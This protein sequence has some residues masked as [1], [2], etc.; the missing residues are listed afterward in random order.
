MAQ[1][2]NPF[3]EDGHEISD[4]DSLHVLT[5]AYIGDAFFELTVREGLMERGNTKVERLHRE[6]VSY[7]RAGSQAE[8]LDYLLKNDLLTPE[9]KEI[10][11]KGRNSKSH[12]MPRNAKPAEYRR[13]TAFEALIGYLY[14]K[15]DKERAYELIRQGLKGRNIEN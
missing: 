12:T 6:T 1:G 7:V 9:E 8:M 14:M 15:G 5:L 11:K 4:P 3:L 10:S 13:A 2:I